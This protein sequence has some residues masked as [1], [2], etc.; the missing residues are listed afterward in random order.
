MATAALDSLFE[1]FSKITDPRDRRGIRHPFQGILVLVF[2]GLLGRMTE[3]AVICRWAR[4][5][6]AVL[7]D[8]LGFTRDEPPCDTT[9]ERTLARFSL[10]EFQAAFNR[11]LQQVLADEQG[12]VAAVDGKTSKQ[13]WQANGNPVQMLNVF[14]HDV[15]A[16]LGQWPLAGDKSTEP[17]MLKAHL[18][19]L[20]AA[21]PA[22]W[23]LTGDALY[24]Q[25]N[26]A[27]ILVE[28]KHHYLFQLKAN[29]PDILDVAQTCFAAAEEQTPDA[30]TREKRGARSNIVV[31]GS[32]W[33]MPSGCES[34]WA[35]PVAICLSESTDAPAPR[36]ARKRMKHATSSRASR[37][38]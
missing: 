12:L 38:R 9:L 3:F 11:W 32:T 37:P 29:Q 17:N 8:P 18:A 16:C 26:L 30:E 19:E 28:S 34:S 7:K 24:C 36:A 4:R 10:D 25:R 14:A 23:L 5:H 33:T 6:W 27:E 21:Y 2:L 22:L 20:F 35:L 31:F 15:R 13:G 1:A